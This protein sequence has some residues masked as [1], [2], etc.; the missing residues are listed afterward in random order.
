MFKAL[1]IFTILALDLQMEVIKQDGYW[2]L[3][4]WNK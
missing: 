4:L 3:I 1:P 2:D